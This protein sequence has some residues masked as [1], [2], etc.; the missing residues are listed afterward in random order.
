MTHDQL[1]KYGCRWGWGI[2][3]SDRECTGYWLDDVYLGNTPKLATE[4]IEG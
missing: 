4:A 3:N 2:D 1:I